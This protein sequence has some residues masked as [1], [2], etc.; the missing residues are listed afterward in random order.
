MKVVRFPVPVSRVRE[1]LHKLSLWPIPE[2]KN[3][4]I[5]FTDIKESY[6]KTILACHPDSRA[7]TCSTTTVPTVRDVVDA[8]RQLVLCYGK[9]DF[10]QKYI[11]KSSLC[12]IG[13]FTPAD[14]A[15]GGGRFKDFTRHD[16]WNKCLDDYPTNRRSAARPSN[17]KQGKT[18]TY[19]G[20]SYDVRKVTRFAPRK[21]SAPTVS[22]PSKND[23]SSAY[24]SV[25]SA[26]DNGFWYS[27]DVFQPGEKIENSR[28]KG[29]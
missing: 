3:E 29:V 14:L 7:A 13:R 23:E 24:K 11:D 10:E 12:E 21:K 19:E 28:K 25:H 15:Y 17:V 6:Q 9:D 22:E 18:V 20:Y 27:K 2:S 1:C 8:Y 4:R 26:D 16:E 5:Y